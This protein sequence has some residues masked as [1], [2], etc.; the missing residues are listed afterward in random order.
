MLTSFTACDEGETSEDSTT[1]VPGESDE[2][3]ADIDEDTLETFSEILEALEASFEDWEGKRMVNTIRTADPLK[4]GEI[5]HIETMVQV[6]SDGNRLYAEV[7]DISDAGNPVLMHYIYLEDE[8]VYWFESAESK[9][10][11]DNEDSYDRMEA[12]E[13]LGDL[14]D[15]ETMFHQMLQF[16]PSDHSIA[17][18]QGMTLL[19]VSLDTDEDYEDYEADVKVM[20]QS[21][22][23]NRHEEE[24]SLEGGRDEVTI[25]MPI[26]T[27]G[28][29]TFEE[30]RFEESSFS[31]DKSQHEE[32]EEERSK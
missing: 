6:D 23:D 27:L 4:S 18:M 9:P 7:S 19:D 3:K 11:I 22:D 16:F 20:M 17:K 28:T 1:D 21:S 15:I 8:T 26:P 30:R 24:W 5:V 10:G 12:S 13:V 29:V 14:P 25:E 2:E 32:N 31:I